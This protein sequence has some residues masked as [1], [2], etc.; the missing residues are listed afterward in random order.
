MTTKLY[1]LIIWPEEKPGLLYGIVYVNWCKLALV[2]ER[3]LPPLES[4]KSGTH[5][6]KRTYTIFTKY[7]RFY[8]CEKL[9]TGTYEHCLEQYTFF[10]ALVHNECSSI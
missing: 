5:Y 7:S 2:R 6:Y 10:G 4:R 8:D 1:H 3:K 9:F